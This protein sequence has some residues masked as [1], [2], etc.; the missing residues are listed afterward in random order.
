[1]NTCYQILRVIGYVSGLSGLALYM[2]GPNAE[3]GTT[4]WSRIAA[5]L[6]VL[7]FVSLLISYFIYAVIQMK[8]KN[9]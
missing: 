8:R 9:R 3:G 7:M 5:G 1:M 6:L 4:V 2:F